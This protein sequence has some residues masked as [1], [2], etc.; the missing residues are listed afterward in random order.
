M[1][2]VG[3][4]LICSYRSLRYGTL[5]T[6]SEAK[7]NKRKTDIT[8]SSHI[9][10]LQPRD[11]HFQGTVGTLFPHSD[12]DFNLIEGGRLTRFKYEDQCLVESFKV[13]ISCQAAS[14]G[15]V[16]VLGSPYL[17]VYSSC[18]RCVLDSA[19]NVRIEPM[20]GQREHR[21]QGRHIFCSKHHIALLS[22][23]VLITVLPCR[24][25]S[26]AESPLT[27][28]DI[29]FLK[30]ESPEKDNLSRIQAEQVQYDD[31][32]YCPPLL[33]GEMFSNI[34]LHRKELFVLHINGRISYIDLRKE[35]YRFGGGEE[36]QRRIELKAPDSANL[37]KIEVSGISDGVMYDFTA[38]VVGEGFL[39]SAYQVSQPIDAFGFVLYSKSRLS[40][41][42]VLTFHR[43]SPEISNSI[44][45]CR[46]ACTIN[47][48]HHIKS[49]SSKIDYLLAIPTLHTIY[50]L[51]LR[52]S[53]SLD[54]ISIYNPKPTI[55]SCL[56]RI[57][58]RGED[59]VVKSGDGLYSI[60]I[61]W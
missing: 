31:F 39:V 16:I 27:K 22:D 45:W 37:P 36:K 25:F 1:D 29:A 47:S 28:S 18:G 59:V 49:P 8:L 5:P 48:M 42:K 46:S 35:K 26:E 57:I 23:P 17:S 33:E 2:R 20:F 40:P 13:K 41:T 58:I 9:H 21:A 14:N 52:S 11:Y 32:D 6:L 61:K 10:F 3:V 30:I 54:L 43:K 50:I 19:E 51:S 44:F 34:Y 55:T 7:Y 4:Y 38:I 15:R 24:Q 53:H 12:S 60:A 56:E